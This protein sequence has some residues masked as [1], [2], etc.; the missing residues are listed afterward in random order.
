ME[1]TTCAF[2]PPAK[3]GIAPAWFAAHSATVSLHA[4]HHYRSRMQTALLVTAAIALVLLALVELGLAFPV[5]WWLYLSVLG[6]FA[7][8]LFRRQPLAK[9]RTRLTAFI[10]LTAVIAALY[11]VPWT[12]RK[13]FLRNLYSIRPGMTESEVRRIMGHYIEGT[14]WPATYGGTPP[15][16]GTLNDLGTGTTHAT[17]STPDGQMTIEGTLVFRHS[18]SGAFDS[19]WGIVAFSNGR[20]TGVSFS[21][22]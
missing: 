12:S 14:G 7:V 6:L 18:T 10:T 5:A 1:Q 22:D 21:P 2:T 9:Q 8:G 4:T 13:P 17:G 11:F 15:G 19:D 20:V 16:S 3:Q